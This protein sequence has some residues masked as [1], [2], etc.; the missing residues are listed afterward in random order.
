MARSKSINPSSALSG[1]KLSIVVLK[2]GQSED[3]TSEIHALKDI[4]L[5]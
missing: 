1:K 2:E 3:L 4:I 5:Y